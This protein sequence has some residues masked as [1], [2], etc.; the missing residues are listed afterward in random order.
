MAQAFRY[1]G[2]DGIR[3]RV[4]AYPITND[5]VVRL[6]WAIGK[7]FHSGGGSRPT[8][9][10]GKDTRISGYMFESALQAGLVSSGCDIHLCGPLATP[11]IA[12]LTRTFRADAG[13]VISASHNPFTDNGIKIFASNGIKIDDATQHSI[14]AK[15]VQKMECVPAIELGKAARIDDAVG[16]YVEFCKSA[17]P[18]LLS[19]KGMRIVLDCA[20]GATYNTAPKVLTELGAETIVLGDNP[21]GFN[22]NDNCGSTSPQAAAEAVQTYRANLG[23]VL[24]GD[25]DRVMMIDAAGKLLDGDDLLYVLIWSMQGQGL[26]RGVV[27]TQQTNMA[28]EEFCAA[29][30]VDFARVNVGDRNIIRAL[31]Q[32]DWNLGAEPSGHIICYDYAT[33]GDGIIAALLVLAALQQHELGLRQACQPFRRY[34]QVL[35]NLPY[36]QHQRAQVEDFCAEQNKIVSDQLG[37]KGRVLLRPSGTE[38][39]L[40]I[41]VEASEEQL[42][43][44]T[45]NTITKAFQELFQD[46]I[47][48]GTTAA[49]Q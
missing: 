38:P 5:F 46:T 44:H 11:A 33:T 8:V 47:K 19:L 3:G 37:A 42:A 35:R 39:L 9:L 12:Y 31:N 49:I 15:L 18:K 10:I 7:T 36:Q 30:G 16:R 2:T 43:T 21:D 6:G 4:G 13:I 27:G 25:G 14:E 34:P 28:L 41:M 45:S 26:L 48:K 17:F 1:F 23:I 32:H 24:D 22:I 40:R 29:K 20:N